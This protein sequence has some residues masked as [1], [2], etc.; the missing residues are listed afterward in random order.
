MARTVT[1]LAKLLDIMVGYDPEDALTARGV[2]HVLA[3][4]T[5]FLDRHGLQEV[6]LG[7]LREAM[8]FHSEPDSED[9]MQAS[10]PL[11]PENL[12]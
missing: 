6:R 7:I 11:T 10:Q 3:S 12:R 9:F 8:G 5:A 2:G 4:Y 1:D